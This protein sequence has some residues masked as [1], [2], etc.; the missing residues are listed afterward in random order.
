MVDGGSGRAGSTAPVVV[1]GIV[2]EATSATLHDAGVAAV[3]GPGG[4]GRR[5]R[6]DRAGAAADG[7]S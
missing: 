4:P 5:G 1:G 7:G 3:L 2:P 6:R